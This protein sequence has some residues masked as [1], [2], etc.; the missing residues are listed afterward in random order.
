MI[1]KY[2][3]HSNFSVQC[4]LLSSLKSEIEAKQLVGE[5]L[6]QAK[7]NLVE[8]EQMLTSERSANET[9]TAEIARLTKRVEELE[10]NQ[11][12]HSNKGTVINTFTL[13]KVQ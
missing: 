2:D 6:S 12:L 5:Q 7:Q 10:N 11:H 4:V 9:L 3:F 13:I 8:T 1:S